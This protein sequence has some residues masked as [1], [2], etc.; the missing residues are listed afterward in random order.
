MYHFHLSN[1]VKYLRMCDLFDNLQNK[2]H[3][4][5]FSLFHFSNF[6][7]WYKGENATG[8]TPWKMKWTNG[9]I[10]LIRWLCMEM[11]SRL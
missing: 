6:Q 5:K 1:Y 3:L 11:V 2:F 10:N 8:N 7:R 4:E 9:V